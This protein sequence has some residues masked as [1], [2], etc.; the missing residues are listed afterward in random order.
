MATSG[1]IG[2]SRVHDPATIVIFG[3]SGD[4]THR[5][6]MPALYIAFA[7]DLLPENFTIVGFAR[8]DYDDEGFRGM[9][10]DSIREFSRLPTDPEKL[11]RFVE[12]IRYHKGDISQMEAYEDL[13]A[14]FEDEAVY[15]PN[16]LFYLSIIPDLFETAVR[17]LKDSGLVE[18]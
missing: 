4:L 17:S 11:E 6:L 18:R 14:K 8:R 3:A 5:K 15:P 9:M 12:R 16:R 2:E 10:A 7:Q 1:I 13:K